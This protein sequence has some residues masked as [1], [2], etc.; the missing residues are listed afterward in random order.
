MEDGR[1]TVE[2]ARRVKGEIP[3]WEGEQIPVLYGVAREVGALRR[4]RRFAAYHTEP[5]AGVFAGE[6]LAGM[7]KN[8]SRIATDRMI[9]LEDAEEGVVCNI[10][11]GHKA[12]EALGRVVS[13]L[14]SA[15]FG[16]TVGIEIDAYRVL[17]SL[18]GTIRASDVREI[19]T[20]LE[21][22][23]IGGILRASP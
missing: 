14:L 12:N 3:S 6:F 16:T 11:A 20:G 9:V 8:R 15:R 5:G 17:L 18:P 22:E 10:C 4:N 19:L 23:H 13:V 7:D 21:P 2:Q 1:I